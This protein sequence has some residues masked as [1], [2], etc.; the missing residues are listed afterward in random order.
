MTLDLRCIA[1]ALVA[2]GVA[3]AGAAVAAA[4]P[5]TQNQSAQ[6]VIDDLTAEGYNVQINSVSGNSSMP[7]S[8]C[9]VVAIHNPNRTGG[10]PT[11]F[12][13]VY[14]D[15]SCPDPPDSGFT[16]GVG[17]GFGFG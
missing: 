16:G 9:S 17:I 1:S 12:T 5:D 7:L 14:V 6:S 10:P 15:V 2:A 13:T 4:D 11:T 8:T 3:V